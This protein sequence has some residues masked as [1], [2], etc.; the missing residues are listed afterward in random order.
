MASSFS[1]FQQRHPLVATR[2][3]GAEIHVLDDEVDLLFL[4]R[5]DCLGG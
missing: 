5:R 1:S 2:G 4:D 3:A